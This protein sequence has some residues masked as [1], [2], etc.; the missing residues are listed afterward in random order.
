MH[1]RASLASRELHFFCG[2]LCAG[3]FAVSRASSAFAWTSSST[4]TSAQSVFENGWMASV[5]SSTCRITPY[6]C[7]LSATSERRIWQAAEGSGSSFSFWQYQSVS[8]LSI[9]MNDYSPAI[10]TLQ[11]CEG[12]PGKPAALVTVPRLTHPGPQVTMRHHAGNWSNQHSHNAPAR[13][14][15]REMR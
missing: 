12:K 11:Q 13:T 14:E 2:P 4:P 5:C 1:G 10:F 9:S 3:F 15:F 7:R 8:I 6:P